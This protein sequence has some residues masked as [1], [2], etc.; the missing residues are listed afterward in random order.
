M[1]SLDRGAVGGGGHI[2]RQSLVLLLLLEK[3]VGAPLDLEGVDPQAGRGVPLEAE[4]SAARRQPSKR[5]EDSDSN[6]HDL[7]VFIIFKKS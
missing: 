2:A 3:R 4:G 1:R 6:K 5:T 7:H